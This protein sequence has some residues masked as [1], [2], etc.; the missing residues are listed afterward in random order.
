MLGRTPVV[1]NIITL[2]IGVF[3]LQ[4]LTNGTDFDITRW[5]SLYDYRADYFFPWQYL[6]H[7]FVHSGF[8]HLFFNMIPVLVLGPYLEKLFGQR[9]FLLFYLGVG[10]G[11][12]VAT[13]ALHAYEINQILNT[14]GIVRDNLNAENLVKFIETV[15]PWYVQ[16]EG[17]YEQLMSYINHPDNV[18]Y[19]ASVLNILEGAVHAIVNMPMMGASGAVFGVLMAAGLYFP[20][21]PLILFPIPIPIKLKWLVILYAFTEFYAGVKPIPGDNVAHFA[22]L[23]G[24]LFALVFYLIWKRKGLNNDQTYY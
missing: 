22:H 2:N 14:A 3:I 15:N 11:A 18:E 10:I 4:Y 23:S 21:M 1:K 7:M 6:T 24:M 12:G 9:K 13:N 17:V 19:L 5:L 20:N 16:N 8:S